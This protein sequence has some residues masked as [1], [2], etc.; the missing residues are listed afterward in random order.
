VNRNP[1]Q[2]VN[3][4]STDSFQR[5]IRL[6]NEKEKARGRSEDYYQLSPKA[7]WEQDNTLGLLDWDVD[8]DDTAA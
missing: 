3:K 2:A 4:P 8:N 5:K 7:Q 1:I 6:I